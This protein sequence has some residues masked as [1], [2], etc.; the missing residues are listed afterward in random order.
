VLSG[1]KTRINQPPQQTRPTQQLKK[2]EIEVA[3]CFLKILF[4][5]DPK[6]I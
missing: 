6:S 1:N 2:I 5:V 3:V 4:D